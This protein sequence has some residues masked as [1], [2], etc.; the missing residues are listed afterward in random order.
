MRF[1]HTADWQIGKPYGA[2]ADEQKRFRLQQERLAAIGRIR[3]VVKL[4]SVDFVLV[5][6]DLFD[7]TTPASTAVLE[8]LEAIGEMQVPVLVIPGN[9]DH[10]APGTVWHREDF[11]RQKPLMAPNLQLLLEQQIVEL[12]QA[13][14]LPCPLLRNQNS[15]DPT[16]WLRHFDWDGLPENKPRI[17]LAH[18]SVHGFGGRN[19]DLE[20]EIQAVSNNQIDLS[21]LPAEQI[22][23]IALGDWHNLKEITTRAWYCGT[24]E[25]DQFD[26]GTDNQRGQVLLVDLERGKIPAVQPQQTGRIYWHNISIS[27]TGDA[28]LDRLQRQIDELTAGRVNRDLL[29]MEISGSL[30]LAGHRRYEQMKN[31]LNDRLL[32]LRIKG[33]CQQA[34][35]AEELEQLTARV[36][37]P[38]IAR[39]ANQLQQQ[40]QEEDPESEQAAINRAALCELFRF[41]TTY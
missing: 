25:P 30:S 12:P 32:R 11:Q 16:S 24:P 5:A 23:Y 41:T 31:D 15:A 14:L 26:Q 37:D 6:G 38:L 8:V 4:H 27:L 39:V 36:E 18:G 10:G 33:E 7:S 1:L 13:V 35:E 19:Y 34:P 21:V 2:V 20:E 40:L 28:D 22:D 9:H 17:V 29:R 3:D